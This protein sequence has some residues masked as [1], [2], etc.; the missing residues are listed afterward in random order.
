MEHIENATTV[1]NAAGSIAWTILSGLSAG[2]PFGAIAV[3]TAGAAWFGG[4]WSI[5]GSF[6]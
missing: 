4:I 1:I 5:I 3:I 2:N 6:V